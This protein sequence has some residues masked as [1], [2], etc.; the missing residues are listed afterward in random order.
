MILVFFSLY[1]VMALVMYSL[2]TD[3]SSCRIGQ[4][5]PGDLLSRPTSRAGMKFGNNRRNIDKNGLG[6][7][8]TA[9]YWIGGNFSY[10]LVRAVNDTVVSI[11]ECK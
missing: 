11:K 6:E 9:I 4:R 7:T 3:V 10:Y 8:D 5:V 2:R 1:V